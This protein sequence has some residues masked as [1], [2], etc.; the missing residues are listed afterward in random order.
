VAITVLHVP[1]FGIGEFAT[2]TCTVTPGSVITPAHFML[3]G[4]K[5]VQGVDVANLGSVIT[6]VSGDFSITIQ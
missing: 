5:A 3:T 1:G 6:S 4:F 2:L